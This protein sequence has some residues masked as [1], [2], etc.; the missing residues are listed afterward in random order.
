MSNSNYNNRPTYH[1]VPVDVDDEEDEEEES[2]FVEV[3]VSEEEDVSSSS[4]RVGVVG[5]GNDS[6]NNNNNN[7]A[8][9]RTT[10]KEEFQ[11]LDERCYEIP[12]LILGFITCIVFGGSVLFTGGTLTDRYKYKHDDDSSHPV[13]LI[14]GM[15]I[16]IGCIVFHSQ[17][18]LCSLFWEYYYL[19]PI[20]QQYQQVG[21]SITGKVSQKVETSQIH[22]WK[23]LCGLVLVFGLGPVG[24]FLGSWIVVCCIGNIKYKNYYVVLIYPIEEEEEETTTP[25]NVYYYSKKLQVTQEE[26]EKST[27]T[28]TNGRGGREENSS[29]LLFTIRII[30]TIPKSAILQRTYQ[31][32]V[33][34]MMIETNPCCFWSRHRWMCWYI[35]SPLLWLILVIAVKES[36]H[37]T[38]LMFGFGTSFL[39]GLCFGYIMVQNKKTTM[40]R[41]WFR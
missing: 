34:T 39:S 13:L 7:N 2:V 24:C 10:T 30:P 26:Y 35:M 37:K 31:E 9:N 11:Y 8:T 28:I 3:V 40:V 32:Y 36:D 5:G 27:T 33:T 15:T 18:K 41:N 38:L 12:I 4:S 25:S 19:K 16:A 17:Y 6:S 1:R 14:F 23:F 29:K 22:F 21:Q 20:L